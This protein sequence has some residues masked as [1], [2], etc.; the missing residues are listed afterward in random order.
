MITFVLEE[1]IIHEHENE[2]NKKIVVYK[3]VH[4]VSKW[5]TYTMMCMYAYVPVQVS[6]T[7]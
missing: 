2:Q 4:L 3:L 7:L 1:L 6:G 5:C